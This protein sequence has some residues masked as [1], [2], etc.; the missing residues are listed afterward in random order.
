MDRLK[1]V[2][3]TERVR[4]AEQD[5]AAALFVPVQSSMAQVR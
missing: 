5:A 2:L 1:V 3:Y 4:R